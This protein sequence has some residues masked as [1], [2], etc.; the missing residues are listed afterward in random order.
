MSRERTHPR[1]I[2]GLKPR[3]VVTLRNY[4]RD[5]KLRVCRW[6]NSALLPKN[7]GDLAVLSLVEDITELVEA[8]ERSRHLAHHDSL[9]GLPNRLLLQDANRRASVPDT[10]NSFV[11]SEAPRRIGFATVR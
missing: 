2:R 6:Y 3:N 11:G 7:G 5:G 4:A 9:T 1:R 10:A 8:E